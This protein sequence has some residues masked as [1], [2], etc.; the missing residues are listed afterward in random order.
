MDSG[1]QF[2]MIT[3]VQLMLM[4]LVNNW[5]IQA[6]ITMIIFPCMF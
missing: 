2:V 4:L 1:G 6:I 5:D 3:L